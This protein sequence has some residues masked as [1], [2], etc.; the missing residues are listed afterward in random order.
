MSR[1]KTYLWRRCEGRFFG[2]RVN[3]EQVPL[4]P[5]CTVARVLDNPRGIPHLLIWRSRDDGTVQEAVR[6]APYREP[7]NPF[8]SDWTGWVEIKRTDGT[9]RLVRTIASEQAEVNPSLSSFPAGTQVALARQMNIFDNKGNLVSTSITESVQIRVYRAIASNSPPESTLQK[10][11]ED[12]GQEFY[13]I[14][15]SRPQIFDQKAGG[16]RAVGSL[17]REFSIFQ[18]HGDDQVEESDRWPLEK[19]PPVLQQCVMCDRR[20]GIQSLDIRGKL[21]KSRFLQQDAPWTAVP[22]S[23]DDGSIS[24]KQTRYDWGLLNGYWQTRTASR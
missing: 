14:R 2:R 15:L 13:E 8:V 11:V 9:R 20:A 23:W 5:A 1:G 16:V 6:V 7:E 12:S 17:E 21:L 24:W 22:Y 3:C 10:A 4:L 18:A 19:H